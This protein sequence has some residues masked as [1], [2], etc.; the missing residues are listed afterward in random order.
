[1]DKKK[2]KKRC[3]KWGAR[4]LQSCKP[5]APSHGQWQCANLVREMAVNV[6]GDVV[7]V[8]VPVP[9]DFIR[10]SICDKHPGSMKS[11][12]HLD[13]TSHCQTAPGTNWLQRWTYR[14]FI[15]NTRRDYVLGG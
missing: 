13:H 6:D 5:D 9:P 7:R 10:T 2:K 3:S 15:T 12:T 14:V 8:C 1:M 4:W 11:T